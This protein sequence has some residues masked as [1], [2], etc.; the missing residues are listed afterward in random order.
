MMFSLRQVILSG[1]ICLIILGVGMAQSSDQLFPTPVRNNE[2]EGAIA[3]RRLG[4]NRLTRYFYEF[5]TSQ[6]DL[7]VNVVTENFNGDIDIFVADSMT[8]VA[9]IVVFADT[10]RNETGRLIYFRKPET[11]LL[12]I[13][14]RT[15]NDEPAKFRIKFGGSFIASSAPGVD[16][17]EAPVVKRPIETERKMAAASGSAQNPDAP[18]RKPPSVENE[19]SKVE[20]G[21][22]NPMKGSEVTPSGTS[23]RIKGPTP[24]RRER[25]GDV[26]GRN[27][28]KRAD[29]GTATR[30]PNNAERKDH[31]GP[32]VLFGSAGS[33]ER[34]QPDPLENIN[35][36]VLLKN[37]KVFEARLSELHTFGFE[38]G[39]LTLRFKDGKIVRYPA[40]ELVKFVVE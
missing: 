35:V 8:S 5:G 14:G 23:R 16:P 29:A 1:L 22:A 33:R 7:F 30:P 38:K 13:E 17:V 6:G 3:A 2:I 11:L 40:A 10:S 9:K 15:P 34:S 39:I 18:A 26:G 21:S 28:E 20:L 25:S 24:P 19:S 12:R 27:S 36:R 37:G 32:A 4:D 31:A